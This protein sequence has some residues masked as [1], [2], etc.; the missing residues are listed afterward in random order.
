MQSLRQSWFLFGIVGVFALAVAWPGAAAPGGPLFIGGW[1]D[2]L[3]VVMFL[4]TGVSLR[5][6]ELG[7]ALGHWRLHL[8]TQG[9]NLGLVPLAAAACDPLLAWCSVPVAWRLGILVTMCLPMTISS[10]VLLTRLAGGSE[11]AALTQ[12]TLG[13]LLGIVVTPLLLL[14]LAHGSADIHAGT[15]IIH[16]LEVVALPVALGQALQRLTPGIIA[17]RGA[18]N[19][20][21][22]VALLVNLHQAFCLSFSQPGMRLDL[23]LLLLVLGMGTAHLVLFAAA[24]AAARWPGWRLDRGERIAVAIC[25]SHKT[26]ALGI[27]LISVLFR[28][29]PDLGLIMLPLVAFHIAENLIDGVLATW[30][31]R[32]GADAGTASA[33]RCGSA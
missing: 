25:A 24:A 23:N 31:R 10:C 2:A 16:L 17:W 32:R 30:I 28:G 5:T 18:L 27:P 26:A 1:Q 11:A 20:L 22:T 9:F 3:F 14:L 8:L 7:A 33:A 13:G 4:A 15:A 12:A 21:S 6:S 19:Q 29:N